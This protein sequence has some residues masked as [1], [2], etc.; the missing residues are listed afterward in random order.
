MS[1]YLSFLFL[2]I[3][4]SISFSNFY[5]IQDKNAIGHLT[6]CQS[7]FHF[8]NMK[9][10]VLISLVLLTMITLTEANCVCHLNRHQRTVKVT[11]NLCYYGSVPQVRIVKRKYGLK[12]YKSCKCTCVPVDFLKHQSEYLLRIK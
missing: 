12:T 11:K 5:K 10:W 1:T 7:D 8:L 2:I 6:H 9:T 4:V 3:W